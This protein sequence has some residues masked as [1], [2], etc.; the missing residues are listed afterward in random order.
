MKIKSIELKTPTHLAFMVTLYLHQRVVGPMQSRRWPMMIIF[1]GGGFD[2]L[3][4]REAEPIA[5][6][7]MA[8]GFQAAV[9]NYNLLDRGQI[10][11]DAVLAGTTAVR[12]LRK[13]AESLLLD[14]SR[15]VTI[16][17]SAGGHV[18]ALV[19]NLGTSTDFLK[20]Y[21]DSRT[22]LVANAQILAYPVI[23][24]LL[25]YPPQKQTIH[26]ITD[27]DRFY[28]AE[29]SVTDQTPPTFL[30][31]TA[32]D[33]TVPVANSLVFGEALANHHIPFDLHIFN[34]GAHGLS[35]AT[36]VTTEEKHVA[37]NQPRVAQWLPLSIQWLKS[38]GVLK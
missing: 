18:S 33:Q 13:Q 11:P 20:Q 26:Q 14:P 15:F 31:H 17:F 34:E 2:H 8:A 9:V 4:P 24:L 23:D 10:Y 27:D 22:S 37:G 25:G 3:S 28:R 16:G 32:Q 1:P 30:M 19:N 29:A 5:L 7:Y 36:M 21:E 12:Y 6:A 35:L 38:L